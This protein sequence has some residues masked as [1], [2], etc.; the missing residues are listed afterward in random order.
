MYIKE[1]PINLINSNNYVISNCLCLTLKF[2]YVGHPIFFG[3]IMLKN[4]RSII[5]DKKLRI[6]E[7][8]YDEKGHALNA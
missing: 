5:Q 7:V 1:H 4:T 3:D 6:H 2:G 8:P